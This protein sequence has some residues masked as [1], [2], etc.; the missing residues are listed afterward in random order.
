MASPVAPVA[1]TKMVTSPDRSA[2]AEAPAGDPAATSAT[3]QDKG[4]EAP[5]PKQPG[6][7]QAMAVAPTIIRDTYTGSGKLDGKIALITGGDSGIGRSVA[8]HFAREGACVRAGG[9]NHGCM[10]ARV[11]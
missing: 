8:V 10:R 1:T 2:L 5:Q 9:L 7:E 6:V 11:S 3:V 4:M